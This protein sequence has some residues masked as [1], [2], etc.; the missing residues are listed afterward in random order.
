MPE[1]AYN[2]LWSWEP[3]IR[4]LFRRLDPKLWRECIQSR[5][6]AGARF[7]RRCSARQPTPVIAL[8]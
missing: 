7:R 3:T 1:L 5:G 4:A 2:I 8:L 6:D